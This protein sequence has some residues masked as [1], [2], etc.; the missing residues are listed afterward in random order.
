MH[1]LMQIDG[2]MIYI[3]DIIGPVVSG[4]A[5]EIVLDLDSRAHVIWRRV[6]SQELTV[7]MELG[8]QFWVAPRKRS[9]R[10]R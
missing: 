4:G 2:G 1:A 6:K 3:L 5:V 8:E 7:K 10:G 9:I